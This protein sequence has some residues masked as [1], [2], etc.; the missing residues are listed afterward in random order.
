M[1]LDCSGLRNGQSRVISFFSFFEVRS[2]SEQCVWS[3]V[4][5]RVVAESADTSP[6]RSEAARS[7]Q[8]QHDKAKCGAVASWER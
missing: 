2:R 1:T 4:R 8:A 3:E 5:A 6:N 7:E